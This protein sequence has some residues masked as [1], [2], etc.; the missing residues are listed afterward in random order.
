MGLASLQFTLSKVS[1]KEIDKLD[2][3]FGLLLLLCRSLI[4]VIHITP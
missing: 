3:L 1:Y 2:V 4:V